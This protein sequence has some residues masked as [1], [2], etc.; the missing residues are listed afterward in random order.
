MDS[1]STFLICCRRKKLHFWQ[2]DDVVLNLLLQKSCDFPLSA[3]KRWKNRESSDFSSGKRRFQWTRGLN[4]LIF[5]HSTII[6]I[7]FHI[8]TVIGIFFGIYLISKLDLEVS[9]WFMYLLPSTER[10]KTN[11]PDRFDNRWSYH[12]V[13]INQDIFSNQNTVI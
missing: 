10:K 7:F 3:W 5:L 8:A 13:G 6:G 12:E 11:S 4:S 9:H 2:A 1:I